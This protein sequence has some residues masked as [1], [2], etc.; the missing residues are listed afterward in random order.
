MGGL[1]LREPWQ[2]GGSAATH[3]WGFT[4][5]GCDANDRHPMPPAS[6]R[7]SWTDIARVLGG[8]LAVYLVVTVTIFFADPYGRSGFRTALQIPNTSQPFWK[9]TRAM[10]PAVDSAI[11]G[12]STSIPIQ[13]KIMDRLTGRKFVS[14]SIAGSGAPV[15][16]AVVRFF[17]RYHADPKA[18]VIALDDSWC[19][20]AVGMAEGRPFPFWLY[21]GNLAYSY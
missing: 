1:P 13:P 20:S 7:Q 8:A 6:D 21:G 11:V 14:L 16:L 19:K 15:A 9:V 12:N 2:R 5:E 3:C 4:R 10:N 17:L 18:L